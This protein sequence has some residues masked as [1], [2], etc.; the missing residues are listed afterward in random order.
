M[1]KFSLKCKRWHPTAL[2]RR[3]TDLPVLILLVL[4]FLLGSV[5]GCAVGSGAEADEVTHLLSG[6]RPSGLWGYLCCLYT[7]GRYHL[8]VLLAATSLLGVVVI[9]ATLLFRGYFLSCAAA[10][11]IASLPEH[12]IAVALTACGISAVLTVPA[13]FLLAMDGFGLSG[14]LR[15]LS[16]GRSNRYSNEAVFSHLGISAV[17]LITAAAAEQL[18]VPTLLSYLL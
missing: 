13:L 2:Y 11:T 5:L 7:V 10:A 3:Q 1:K 8:V 17:C 4:C 14:R 9:P 6:T 12:G 15:A 16:A 18:L